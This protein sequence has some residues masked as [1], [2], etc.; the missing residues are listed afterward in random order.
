MKEKSHDYSFVLISM[1][2]IV[3]IVALVVLI[4]GKQASPKLEYAP[5]Q[6]TAGQAIGGDWFAD[7]D[8]TVMW[9]GDDEQSDVDDGDHGGGG[10][11]G[12][13]MGQG[14]VAYECWAL[15]QQNECNGIGGDIGCYW[16]PN[17]P[18]PSGDNPG[19]NQACIT[20]DQCPSSCSS[21]STLWG[22]PWKTC[23]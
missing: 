19:C 13:C 7:F 20:S 1:V 17:C 3:A 15:N 23:Q 9:R 2:A 5:V 22:H 4:T 12:C 10:L 14:S 18:G 16:E 6:D 11:N 8:V 21:C